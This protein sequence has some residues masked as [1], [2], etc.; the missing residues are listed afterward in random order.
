MIVALKRNL[1]NNENTNYG[2]LQY[3]HMHA[4]MHIPHHF[5]RNSYLSIIDI[6]R[7]EFRLHQYVCMCGCV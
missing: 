3:S 7:F 5:I 6:I 2:L 4:H 1:F